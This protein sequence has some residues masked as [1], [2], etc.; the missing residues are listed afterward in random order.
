[1]EDIK[2][3]QFESTITSIEKIN[4]EFSR[5]RIR[6]LYAG[7]N[8]NN[9]YFSKEVIEKMLP[10]IKNIPVIGEWIEEDKSFGSHGGRVEIDDNGVRFVDTTVPIGLVPSDTE[11]TWEIVREKDGITEHEYLCCTAFLWTGRYKNVEKVLDGNH[12][13]SM[14]ISI[15][16]GKW[17]ENDCY[18]VE[19]A[20]FSALC[21]LDPSVEPCFESSK[22]INYS[23]NKEEFKSE[24]NQMLNELKFSLKEVKTV[25]DETNIENVEE[26]TEEI[27]EEV[28]EEVTETFEENNET[29]DIVDE[30]EGEKTEVEINE[31]KVIVEE[32]VI[33]E[34]IG[35]IIEENSEENID[36]FELL[37]NEFN[38][39]QNKIVELEKLNEELS[40]FKLDIETKEKQIEIDL[41]FE[42]FENEISIENLTK[43][44]ENALS[45]DLTILED[46]LCALAYK[47]KKEF[48]K[49]KNNNNVK[50]K[51]FIPTE[52]NT[53]VEPYGSA[54]AYF[55]KK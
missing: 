20:L 44:R 35:E 46:Q 30:T 32:V 8:R 6:V 28:K 36:E 3:L 52:N 24:F 34:I 17:D 40:N 37:K 38:V 51:V 25:T 55:N 15:L 2:R 42:N 5:V 11:I 1:L 48:S 26:V 22:I 54:S 53:V 50:S 45:M 27:V 19:D 47:S 43:L 33:K 18:I 31:D 39:L 29:S 16:K 13:H 23:F 12:N 49:S 21:V 14:E 10:T 4:P 7:K 9:S 41:L